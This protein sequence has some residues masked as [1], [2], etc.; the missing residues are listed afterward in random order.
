MWYAIR[1]L[2]QKKYLYRSLNEKY[3]AQGSLR[4]A[5][6]YLSSEEELDKHIEILKN[7]LVHHQELKDVE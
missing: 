3:R 4:L 6:D 7:V 2:E 1:N 5:A